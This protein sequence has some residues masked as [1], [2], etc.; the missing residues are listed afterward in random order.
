MTFIP[1]RVPSPLVIIKMKIAA[2]CPPDERRP[3]PSTVKEARKAS[4]K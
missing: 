4:S 2:Q 1:A 3:S